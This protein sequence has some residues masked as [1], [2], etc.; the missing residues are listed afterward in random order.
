MA[1]F[2]RHPLLIGCTNRQYSALPQPRQR[3]FWLTLTLV[4]IL[5]VQGCGLILDAVKLVHP[6][7][8]N[9]LDAICRRGE[10][11]VGMAVEPF[12]PFVFP[13]L[14]TDEGARVTGLDVELVQLMSDAL[15]ERCGTPVVPQLHLIRFRDLFLLLNEGR[16]D[17]FVSAVARG[18]PSPERAGIAYSSPYFREGGLTGV[19]KR[20]EILELIQVRLGHAG[21]G[22]GASA[23]NGLAIAVQDGTDAHW[24]AQAFLKPGRLIVCD[25]LPAA[26]EYGENDGIAL[27]DVILGAKPVLDFVVKTTRRD[28]RS[29]HDEHGHPLVFTDADYGVVMAEESYSLRWLINDT[30]FKLHTSGRLHSMRQRWLEDIYAYPRRAS[31]EG[32]SFDVKQMPTHYAQGTCRERVVPSR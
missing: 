7:M 10:I 32:L 3:T 30:I 16:L 13:A 28:W 9:E 21:L 6:I 19:S 20:P 24:Y 29:L 12:R 31:T 8:T 11:H 26:F 25:S 17:F 1:V 4:S 5:L 15:T 18:T 22:A 27:L 23:L 2:D 14:W